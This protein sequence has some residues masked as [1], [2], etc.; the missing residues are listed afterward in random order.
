[1]LPNYR[2]PPRR[3]RELVDQSGVASAAVTGTLALVEVRS[4]PIPKLGPN[5]C[6]VLHC[7]WKFVGTVGTKS[8]RAYLGGLAGAAVVWY[9]AAATLTRLADERRIQNKTVTNLQSVSQAHGSIGYATST[10]ADNDTAIETKDGTTIT[11]AAQLTDAAD[12]AILKSWSIEII[13]AN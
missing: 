7:Q 13:R 4:V 5:D 2:S 11:F 12:Q 6:I 1:M 9:T 3:T 10:G 8:V